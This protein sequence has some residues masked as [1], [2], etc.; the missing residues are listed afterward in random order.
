MPKPT[1]SIT[2]N[3]ITDINIEVPTTSIWIED[4]NF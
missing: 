1:I 4:G 2:T 3:K